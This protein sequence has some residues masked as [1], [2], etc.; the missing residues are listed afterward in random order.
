MILK[1]LLVFCHKILRA[2]NIACCELFHFWMEIYVIFASFCY[3]SVLFRTWATRKW[4]SFIWTFELLVG[5]LVSFVRRINNI[6]IVE[7]T[8]RSY[9]FNRSVF[10][11]ISTLSAYSFLFLSF[12]TL[13]THCCSWGYIYFIISFAFCTC[14][15]PIFLWINVSNYFYIK[16]QRVLLI[17]QIWTTL[18]LRSS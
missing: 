6:C 4:S 17:E 16:R 1:Y 5:I 15:L 13:T 3:Y 18:L 14:R 10:S 12:L 9:F 2:G 11:Q 7:N 8:F